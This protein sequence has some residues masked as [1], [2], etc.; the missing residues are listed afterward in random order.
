MWLSEGKII[1]YAMNM[2][3]NFHNSQTCFWCNV[4]KYIKEIPEGYLIIA[5]LVFSIGGKLTR[6]IVKLKSKAF[7]EEDDKSSDYNGVHIL[8]TIADILTY[9]RQYSE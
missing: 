7:S 3:N 1:N 5:D 2:P 6:K 9:T 4:Y 8:F